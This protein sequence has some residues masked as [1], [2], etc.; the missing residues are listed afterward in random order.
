MWLGGAALVVA[1]AVV[2][3]T[4]RGV[5]VPSGFQLPSRGIC[6][7]TAGPDCVLVSQLDGRL[8][9]LTDGLTEEGSG[10]TRPFTHP[11][12]FT[13]AAAVGE[14]NV[15]VGCADARIRA[16]DLVSG[17]QAWELVV[18][19]AASPPTLASGTVFF[20]TDDGKVYAA[21]TE[22]GSVGWSVPVGAVVPA[23]PLVTDDRVF[24]GT[25]AGL[26]HCLAR[27][28]G[29]KLWRAAL[30]APIYA[31]PRVVGDA[32]FV[33]ADDGRVHKLDAAGAE[34]GSFEMDGL[35][36]APVGVDGSLLVAGDSA[37]TVCRID[38]DTLSEMWRRRLRGTI[39]VA[40]V[41]H[42]GRVYCAAGSELVC[43]TA[44]RGRILWRRR[45]T[46]HGTDLILAGTRLL[47]ATADGH[48]HEI[49]IKR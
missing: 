1:M 43:L 23:A 34:V 26:V 7:L 20:G 42:A 5:R 30:D 45:A 41:V 47:W 35:V 10:W 22:D 3:A 12:G 38:P 11:A 36:R 48:V 21:A 2:F 4:T 14:R 8:T 32:C 40:P 37:G 31:S 18:G 27:G 19:A 29:E 39:A 44:E 13:G 16:V 46:A 17:V 15:F 33:G 49:A 25:T 6:F 24:A 9:R 28:D